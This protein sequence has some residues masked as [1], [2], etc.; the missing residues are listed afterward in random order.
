MHTASSQHT[1]SIRQH[2]R[3][4]FDG[5]H[6]FPDEL[7]PS[8]NVSALTGL[9]K[10]ASSGATPLAGGRKRSPELSS[11]E[12]P[13]KRLKLS[14]S[15]SSS[16]GLVPVFHH[17]YDLRYT[18]DAPDQ[19][20]DEDLLFPRSQA[21]LSH[22]LSEESQLLDH[23]CNT[24]P[25]SLSL[26]LGPVPVGAYRN[27]LVV[28]HGMNPLEEWHPEPDSAHWLLLLPPLSDDLDDEAYDFTDHCTKDLAMASHILRC[29]NRVQ[30]E[31]SI[32]LITV[33]PSAIGPTHELPFRLQV[34]MIVHLKIPQIFDTDYRFLQKKPMLQIEDAQRRL[35]THAFPLKSQLPN[36]FSGKIDIP[37]FYSVLN[38][39]PQLL[40]IRAE[41]SMQ[42]NGLR[43]TLLPFQRRSVGWL[44]AREG[45]APDAAG[46]ILESTL[47]A[48]QPP[49]PVF[50]EMIDREGGQPWYINRLTGDLLPSAPVED[51]IARGGILAEEPGLGKTLESISLIMLDPPGPERNPTVELWDEEARIH[52]K[53]V[54]VSVLLAFTLT[55]PYIDRAG[56]FR[57]L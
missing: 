26:D 10:N 37:F 13:A 22:W 14:G 40:S 25:D 21:L 56:L 17:T 16:Q 47:T 35:L 38:P 44:L 9:V 53:E 28:G 36:T 41:E 43:A 29:S 18:T 4:Y 55:A 15:R 3:H 52:V 39:A 46:R 7:R 45:K 5:I 54:G 48:Q 11:L 42:P 33:P 23:L 30:V 31:C 12:E 20:L 6:G 1:E 49:L 34:D 8:L 50:W 51:N 24:H 2:Y 32:R 27:R 57:Q 19:G